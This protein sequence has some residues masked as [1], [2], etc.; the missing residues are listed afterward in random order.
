[1]DSNISVMRHPKTLLSLW[2]HHEKSV[3][4]DQKITFMGGLDLCFGR[5]DNDHYNLKEPEVL[6]N[7][8]YFPG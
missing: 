5:Y 7:S 2:S 1:M 3:T 4:I 8:L 6:P